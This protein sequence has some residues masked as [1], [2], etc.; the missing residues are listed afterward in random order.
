MPGFDLPHDDTAEVLVQPTRRR[1]FT[2]LGELGRPAST[3]V[4]AAR[5]GL[6]PNGVRAHLQ[7]M[8]D[9]GLL[10]HMRVAGP[11]G[12]PRDEWAVSPT[13]R[14]GGERPPATGA[15]ARWLARAIPPT[16]GR[17]EEVEA[18]GR[19][20][21]RELAPVTT[22]PEAAIT[23]VITALGF[24]PEV[25]ASAPGRLGCVLRNCP[26]REAVRENRAVVCVL[27][28]GLVRGL[29]DGVAPDATLERFVPHDPDEAG[30]EIEIGAL[31]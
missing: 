25:D 19:A 21:G 10:T 23:E 31:P 4:L 7:R 1:L 27:H 22:S 11:R 9:A 26:Y 18:A 2:L 3:D 13:A 17:L 28:R 5:L 15:L 20:I 24:Q 12:R 30:C 14:P 29:L 6:H 8:R 16:P